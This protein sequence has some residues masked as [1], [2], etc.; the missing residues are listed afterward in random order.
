MD[1]VLK[2]NPL[3]KVDGLP[4]FNE[5]D[6][7]HVEPAVRYLLAGSEEKVVELEKTLMPT[8]DG[9]L[10]PLEDM[11]VNW[12][13]AWSP[14]YHL[15]SVKNSPN[16]RKAH[17]KVLAD[18][19][20][21]GLRMQQS[22][23]IYEGL[24]A[25]FGGEGWK[26]LD[27]AQQRVV[28]KKLQAAERAGVG[29]EGKAKER[30]NE[31]AR[32]LSQIS[33]DFSNHVLDSTKAFALDVTDPADTEGWPQSLKQMAAQTYSR[34]NDGADATPEEGPWR[35]T[36]DQPSFMP[37]VQHSR[38]RDQ[39]EQVYRAYITRACEGEWDNTAL[40]VSALKLRKEKAKLLGYETYADLS[41]ES[42]MAPDVSAVE[43]MF[44]ELL[45]ASKVHASQ[46]TKDLEEIAREMGQ[47]EPLAHWDLAFYSERLREKVYD[48]TEDQLRPYFP[49]PKVLDGLFGLAQKLFGITVEP[50]AGEVRVWHADVRY[51]RV[52]NEEGEQI[53]SFYLDPYSRPEDKRGG[54]WMGECLSR[55]ILD[56]EVR[57]PVVHLCCNGTPPVGDKPSLMGFREVQTLFHEFGH[58]LQAMLTTVDYADVAG[59]NGVE[60]D[61]VELASQFMENWL[62]HKPTL[63]GMTEH[64]E[65]GERLPDDLFEKLCAARTFR[66]G[67]L[68]LRQLEFGMT[69]MELHGSY[70]PEGKE[71][72]F[73]VHH[74]IA[75]QTSPLPPLKEERFL[76]AF[77]HIFSGAYS[78]GYY[79]YKW[80]E[81]LSADAFAAFEDVGLDHEDDVV[82]LGRRF[83]DTVLALGGGRHPMD[84]FR[85]FRGREPSTEALLRHSGLL[86]GK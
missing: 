71:S 22:R 23:P 76:C 47:E 31:I 35:I 14:V 79:S 20:A 55:R 4:R 15:L 30:F 70:D 26:G 72:A 81:V 68:M 50:V 49:M 74:R 3:L 64:V 42:K 11:D 44:E 7:A 83:R 27:E 19:V 6:P 8:W 86:N 51:F 13:Y 24:K 73:E 1:E 36:L 80:S 48:F 82:K 37:F 41:L 9:L 45:G 77:S 65:T 39:R 29:L 84:V 52:Q 67:S 62:Y 28:E 58:G 18:V 66:A 10:Q 33:T 2:N 53:A 16:L 40:I 46:E 17:E 60:W 56:G 78:A 25:L 32:E 54:A 61:A 57:L 38:R 69:D 5:V 43:Q 21:F 12:E 34:A 59:V 63:V 75:K 85:D